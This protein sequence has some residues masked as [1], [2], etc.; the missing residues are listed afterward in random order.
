MLGRKITD[1]RI[2][3]ENPSQGRFES[4]VVLTLEDGEEV[5]AYP[6][7]SD[8]VTFH[9]SDF[10]GKTEAEADALYLDRMQEKYGEPKMRV[11]QTTWLTDAGEWGKSLKRGQP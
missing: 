7:F 3:R 6:F 4:S 8:W 1:A 9:A 11:G 2:V 5:Y 10:I